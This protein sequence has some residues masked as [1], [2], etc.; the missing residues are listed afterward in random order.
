MVK[1]GIRGAIHK[2]KENETMNNVKGHEV[3]KVIRQPVTGEILFVHVLKRV[4]L[5]VWKEVVEFQSGL[6]VDRKRLS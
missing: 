5:Q 1:D 3:I 2:G 4:G 6:V